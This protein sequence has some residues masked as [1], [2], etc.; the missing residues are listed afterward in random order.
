MQTRDSQKK[1]LVGFANSMFQASGK[2]C[3]KSNWTEA[4]EQKTVPDPGESYKHWQNYEKDLDVMA[5]LGVNS[6]RFSI[7]WSHIQPEKDKFDEDVLS[8]YEKIIDACLARNIQPMLTLYHFNE[9]LWFTHLGSFEKEENISYFL[10]FC[11]KVF[12]RFNKKVKLWCTFNEPA[13]QAFSGYLYGQFP[14]HVHSLQRTITFLKNL[15]QAHTKLYHQLKQLPEGESTKIGIVHNVLRFLPLCQFELL[16]STLAYF[17]TRITDELV[18]NYLKTGVYYYS[19]F[20]LAYENYTNELAPK[21]YDFIG[22]NFYA[23]AVIGFNRKNFFGPTYFRGQ[24]MGDMYL[25][26]D[27]DGF[28]KAIDEVAA[29]G[30]P[31][32][33][34]EIGMA[35]HTDQL[36]QKLLKEYFDI[37]DRKRQEGIEIDGVFAWTLFKN[38]EWNEGYVPKFGLFDEERQKQ[39]SALVFQDFI[40]QH[41]CEESLKSEGDLH[42]KYIK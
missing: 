23:N 37:I 16:E 18:M 21:S 36:R 13:V 39:Q 9:P 30:K 42:L 2:L 14:P 27:P 32:Y 6:Y 41:V 34:T 33:I 20:L 40:K 4:A 15:L 35:D 38:F 11:Q 29:L 1:M 25:P 22:L 24:E 10:D 8:H 5:E 12:D 3:G 17:M 26:I 19:F 31:I 28:A 7:E